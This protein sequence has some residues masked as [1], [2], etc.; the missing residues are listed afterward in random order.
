MTE[1][2]RCVPPSERLNALSIDASK[3]AEPPGFENVAEAWN[4]FALKLA[5]RAPD[6]RKTAAR[7]R[8]GLRP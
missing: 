3:N 1:N 4:P 5:W 2:M 7:G 8:G 6:P